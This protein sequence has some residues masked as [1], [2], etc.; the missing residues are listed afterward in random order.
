MAI[1]AKS[2][3]ADTVFVL[4]REYNYIITYIKRNKLEV[5]SREQEES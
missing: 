3:Y 4:P 1:H 2:F 5:A